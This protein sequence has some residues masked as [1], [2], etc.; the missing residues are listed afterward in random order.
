MR[1][2]WRPAVLP[3]L[4]CSL[5]MAALA[6]PAFAPPLPEAALSREPEIVNR[7]TCS[8]CKHLQGGLTYD[9][10]GACVY[11]SGGCHLDV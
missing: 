9:S 3:Y 1:M 8:V 10:A 4:A 7:P 6:A 5:M 11:G 2:R